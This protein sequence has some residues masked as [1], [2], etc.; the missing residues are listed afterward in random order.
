MDVPIELPEGTLMEHQ[1]N[2]LQADAR[3]QRHGL[4]AAPPTCRG[5]H[6]HIRPE[7]ET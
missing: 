7:M 3:S 5:E 6:I 4:R 2:S 1:N